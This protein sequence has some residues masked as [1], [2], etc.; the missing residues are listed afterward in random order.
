MKS[1][2]K[3][4]ITQNKCQIIF[5]F[6]IGLLIIGV[7]SEIPI[8]LGDNIS[9]LSSCRRISPVLVM[10]FFVLYLLKAI[11]KL[12]RNHISSKLGKNIIMDL[13][14]Q[15]LDKYMKSDTYKKV[16]TDVYQVLTNDLEILSNLVSFKIFVFIEEIITLAISLGIMV[17]LNPNI[18]EVLFLFLVCI[19]VMTLWYS[20]KISGYIRRIRLKTVEI[21]K[22]IR[23]FIAAQK[24]VRTFGSKDYFTNEFEKHLKD[25]VNNKHHINISMRKVFPS[26]ELLGNILSVVC[27]ISC[28]QNFSYQQKGL[29]IVLTYF[30]YVNILVTTSLN[31]LNI[32]NYFIDSKESIYRISE[33]CG[34]FTYIHRPVKINLNEDIVKINIDNVSYTNINKTI[35]DN[36]SFSIKK[37]DIISICGKSGVGKTVLANILGGI[38][39]Q[40]G[41]KITYNDKYEM[42]N[43]NLQGLVGYAMQVPYFFSDTIS[44]NI[45]LGR[46]EEW[47]VIH[48]MNCDEELNR[49]GLNR[50]ITSESINLSVGEKKMISIIRSCCLNEHVLVFDDSFE[51]VD[52][53]IQNRLINWMEESK[54]K[55][56]IYIGNNDKIL[57]I[58]DRR[59]V[60]ENKKIREL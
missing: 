53:N 60:L 43:T 37:G 34:K 9:Y 47:N 56:I 40:Y 49:I 36:I 31:L 48:K 27:I 39:T 30:S 32:V 15:I 3:N 54:E 38:E 11:G 41:G 29:G 7:T 57:K 33:I 58:S 12:L 26:I 24:L 2:Y 13:R 4:I 52:V 17:Y 6:I 10:E 51:G 14:M 5:I 16:K 20:K 21:I 25:Y 1:I 35:L 8:L 42:R 19:W 18:I 23:E 22:C 44:F 55:I 50:E 59:Y 46:K 28:M 45:F